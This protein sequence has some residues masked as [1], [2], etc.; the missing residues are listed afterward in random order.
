M[1]KEI[2]DFYTADNGGNVHDD[3]E[4]IAIIRKF[5]TKEKV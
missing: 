5:L 1:A 4:T 2:V 3:L